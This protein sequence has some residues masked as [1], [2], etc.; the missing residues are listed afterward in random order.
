MLEAV[1]FFGAFAGAVR[2]QAQPLQAVAAAEPL[3]LAGHAHL[4]VHREPCVGRVEQS[5]FLG[6]IHRHVIFAAHASV[7]E[8]DDDLLPDSFEITVSPIFKREGR[9][10]ATAFG[11]GPLITSA[12]GMR[13]DLVGLAV[14]DVDAAPVR[15]PAR[16]AGGEMLIGVGNSLVVLFFVFV[17]F[18]VRSG[19]A[20]LPESLDER[21]ALF[22]VAQLLK[23]R[24]LFV[25]DDPDYVLIE[26]LLVS[27][28][29]FFPVVLFLLLLFLGVDG[30]FE[31]IG[32]LRGLC[33]GSSRSRV[34][35]R[36]IG[37]FGIRILGQSTGRSYAHKCQKSSEKVS[38]HANPEHERDSC[39]TTF[40]VPF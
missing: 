40:A 11:H 6:A 1:E 32:L 17:L 12:R 30:P 37:R 2:A 25:G 39:Q 8:L 9:R 10:L 35:S 23:R 3:R 18:R 15:F 19:I 31:R 26:P 16:N 28:F 34:S 14:H 21:I 24:L 5:V 33:R 36:F 22:V 13:L 29:D 27:P 38:V 20:T 7:D 4:L